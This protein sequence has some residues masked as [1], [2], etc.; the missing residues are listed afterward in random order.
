MENN[1]SENYD[2][3]NFHLKSE[4]L[5]E[6]ENILELNSK[7]TLSDQKA[8]FVKVFKDKVNE[9]FNFY[10]LKISPNYKTLDEKNE[11]ITNVKLNAYY[12]L[13][14]YLNFEDF[15][16][17]KLSALYF[18]LEGLL[19]MSKND[20]FIPLMHHASRGLI[21]SIE[22]A[23]SA[24]DCIKKSFNIK[25][26]DETKYIKEKEYYE[27]GVKLYKETLYT[28]VAEQAINIFLSKF[29]IEYHKFDL[30]DARDI[31]LSTDFY[32]IENADFIAMIGLNNTVYF[33]VGNLDKNNQD[34]SIS[35]TISNCYHMAAHIMIEAG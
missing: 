21:D 20:L 16:T 22:V 27:L 17:N 29:N 15:E 26:I 3:K 12:R 31:L 1:S 5:E 30:K 8:A 6:I 10:N 23:D 18:F 14:Y 32:L 9:Y 2:I 28:P 11:V 24:T 35:R 33:N 13:Y 19:K 7:L 34:Y 4:K 25:K